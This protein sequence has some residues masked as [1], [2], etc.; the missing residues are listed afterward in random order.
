MNRQVFAVAGAVAALAAGLFAA[1]VYAG[2]AGES[3]AQDPAAPRL[4]KSE[5][6]K[7]KADCELVVSW[8]DAFF[9]DH[10]IDSVKG[11]LGP[12]VQHNPSIP[13]GVKPL[14][15]FFGPYFEKNP[16]STSEIVRAA[17]SGD[18]VWLQVHEYNKPS[19]RKR[20]NAVL[21]IFRVKNGKIVEHWDI[22]QAVPAKSA[23]SNTMF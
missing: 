19:E 1:Q 20:G 4:C 17:T 13:N 5:V 9:N 21:D 8:Y 14:V 11:V 10:E 2:S 6:K 3:K 16:Q 7:E 15:D 12:Y 22:I 23:N 18:L